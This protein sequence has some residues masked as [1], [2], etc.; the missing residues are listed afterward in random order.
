MCGSQAV[1]DLLREGV[2]AGVYP[3][4]VLLSARGGE[5]TRLAAVGRRWPEQE[6][7]PMRTDTIFDLA[8]LT[9]PL[10]TTLAAMKL[11]NDGRLA[12]GESLE[13]ALKAPL[14]ADKRDIRVRQLLCHSAGLADW[15]PFYLKLADVAA[16]ER[17]AEIQ[18]QILAAPLIYPPGSRSLYSDLGF[19]LLE[20]VIEIA[21]GMP[22]AAFL[23]RHFYG[24]LG[25]KRT[26]LDR[27]GRGGFRKDAFAP[28]ENCPW[29]RQTM[30]GRVHDENAFAV[31]GHSGHAGLFGVAE[32]VFGIAEL[33]REHYRGMRDDFLRPETVQAFFSRQGWV[34]GNTFTLGWDTPSPE[35]SSCGRL[36]SR[37]SVGH[38]G[39]TGTSLW[40]DLDKDV[41]VVLLTNRVH[42]T[43]NNDRIRAF[44]PALHEAIIKEMEKQA[45][46][47]RRQASGM[48]RQAGARGK[49]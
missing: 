35:N 12:L 6:E 43:R 24:P 40:M 49:A 25:L 42:P 15:K 37:R 39:F 14:P 45:S 19:M 18:R 8:S 34:P 29:R 41:T 17:K 32:E 16:E 4:A 13:E 27:G 5:R 11:V 36:F 47:K 20:R 28:T 26:F 22:M 1:E 2:K 33:L 38:L 10:A 46:S 21:A 30:V 48:R 44:R 23:K 31:G 7:A 3:G 9:K